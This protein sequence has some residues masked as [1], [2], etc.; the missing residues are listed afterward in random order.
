MQSEFMQPRRGPYVV[1]RSLAFGL[2]ER[3]VEATGN[4]ARYCKKQIPQGPKYLPMLFSSVFEVPYTS[5]KQGI[6]DHEYSGRLNPE[7]LHHL[8]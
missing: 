5:I 2:K 6:W 1:L 3:S 4:L 7:D 8:Q